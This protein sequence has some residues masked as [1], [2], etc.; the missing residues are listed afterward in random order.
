[1]R[2]FALLS[3]FD[4]HRTTPVQQQQHGVVEHTRIARTTREHYSPVKRTSDSLSVESHFV[5][6]SLSSFSRAER[7]TRYAIREDEKKRER[8]GEFGFTVADIKAHIL[9]N[10]P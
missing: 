4:K 6:F 10:F 1:V 9:T 2:A 5:L 3:I 8:E 7:I